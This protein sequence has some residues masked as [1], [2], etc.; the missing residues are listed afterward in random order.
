M[1]QKEKLK[2]MIDRSKNGIITTKDITRI[3]IHRE[4]LRPLVRDSFLIPY[5]RGVYI[6]KD[7]W[8]DDLFL[9]QQKY[10]KGIY[11]Y[12]TALYLLNFSNSAPIQYSM[13]FQKGFLTA[14]LN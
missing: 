12:E 3:G 13:T 11:S 1:T 10:K 6:K 5:C 2:E 7:T 8:E 4:N 14:K 9:L